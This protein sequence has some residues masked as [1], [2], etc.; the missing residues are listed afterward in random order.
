MKKNIFNIA[1]EFLKTSKKPLI[2]IIGP[3]A[4]GKTESSILLAKK[5]N[6][7]IINADSKQIFKGLDIATAMITKKEKEDIPHHLFSFIEPNQTFTVAEWKKCAEKK[8]AE[9]LE[10]NKIPILCGGTGLYINAITKN[11]QIPPIPPQEDF[12]QE[13]ETFSNKELFEKLKKLNPLASKKLHINNKKAIIRALE[14]AKFSEENNQQIYLKNLNLQKKITEVETIHELCLQKN[15]AK[16]DNLIFGVSVN[17]AK[18]YKR[19]NKRVEIMLDNGLL[20]EIKLLLKKNY[21]KTDPGLISHGVPE[22]IDYLNHKISQEEFIE[23]MQKGTRHYAKR[24]LTWW[25]KDERIIWFEKENFEIA[26][27]PEI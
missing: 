25:R 12:R 11:F 22:A 7:E 19:I 6:G 26:D 24:Q 8:C 21:K 17:R 1:E 2:A 20:T 9:I 13:M 3:T 10:K 23:K 4:S 16:F 18:L 14:I 5:I 15:K 27:G